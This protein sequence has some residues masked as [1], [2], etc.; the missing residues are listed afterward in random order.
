MFVP[1]ES[2]PSTSRIWIY[3][4]DRPFENEQIQVL[5][6]ILSQF[7]SSWETHGKPI[8]SSFRISDKQ[9]IIIAVD[10]E[11]NSAS[12]CSID[13]SVLIIKEIEQQTG[14]SLLDRT[15][16]GWKKD[17][18]VQITALKN[19]RE[20][21]LEGSISEE[22]VIFNNTISTLADLGTKW[23]I[24]ASDSWLSRYFNN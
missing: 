23:Q 22:T 18:E 10:E 3:Q 21:V 8:K 13:K 17:N 5:G 11:F 4:S 14:A 20:K 7:C 2:L 16:V 24:K 12:G 15:M 6:E 19:I 1:F 9:F